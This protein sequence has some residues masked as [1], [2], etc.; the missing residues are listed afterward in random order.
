MAGALDLRYFYFLWDHKKLMWM[1]IQYMMEQGFL[2]DKPVLLGYE[3]VEEQAAL[4]KEM[5]LKY[6]ISLDCGLK[7][8][9]HLVQKMETYL[10]NLADREE[11]ILEEVLRAMRQLRNT[12]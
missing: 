11:Q 7:K 3:Q 2:P 10:Q 1:R 5:A 4:L 8:P 9:E 12:H 6:N